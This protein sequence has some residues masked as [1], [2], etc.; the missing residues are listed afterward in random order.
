[1]AQKKVS[2]VF[3]LNDV[4]TRS[5]GDTLGKAECYTTNVAELLGQIGDEFV[6]E[7]GNIVK[8]EFSTYV[9]LINALWAKVKETASECEG[10][11]IEVTLPSNVIGTILAAALAAVG[12]KL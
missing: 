4:S 9:A 6:D 5:A 7:E 11:E 3:G 12:I 10:K 1:M 8:F 2:E